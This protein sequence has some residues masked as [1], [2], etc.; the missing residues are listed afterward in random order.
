MLNANPG[1]PAQLLWVVS[2]VF[3]LLFILL[4]R[5]ILRAEA[6]GRMSCYQSCSGVSSHFAQTNT[7]SV[8]SRQ[9]LCGCLCMSVWGS[10]R[11]KMEGNELTR[12]LAIH[13]TRFLTHSFVFVSKCPSVPSDTSSDTQICP[14]LI[15]GSTADCR[16]A[17]AAQ[18]HWHPDCP[19]NRGDRQ[20][21]TQD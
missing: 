2:E 13:Q 9:P 15:Y 8:S 21:M 3:S 5:T 19:Q 12:G 1:L 7:S 10:A 4:Y 17:E 20:G 16:L 11:E 14:L 6:T 18:Y